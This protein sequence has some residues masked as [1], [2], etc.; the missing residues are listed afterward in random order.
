M[1]HL[2]RW[3][4]PAV[5]FA[6]AGLMT[7]CGPVGP[8]VWF[9][10]LP[11]EA[12]RAEDF[13]IVAGDAVEINV[14]GHA[15]MSVKQK[16]RADGQISMPIIGEI[17]ARNKRPSALR[18]ELEARLKQ[19]IVAPTVTV[20]VEQTPMTIV[21]LGEVAKPGAY[22]IEPGAGLANA[23]ALAGGLTDFASRDRIFIVRQ[24]PAPLR[25]RFTFDWVTRNEGHAAAFPLRP[26]D[27]LVVE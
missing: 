21:C 19:Y 13:L 22:P 11:P 3:T 23:L 7:A 8:Y 25:V 27:L 5:A 2:D 26:G 17:E 4:R 6:I 12:H 24:Q 9:S 10:Q 15:D 16:V 14:L 1:I 18:T 20:T